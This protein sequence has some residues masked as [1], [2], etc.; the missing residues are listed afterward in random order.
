[1]DLRQ[2]TTEPPVRILLVRRHHPAAIMK[3]MILVMEVV[4]ELFAIASIAPLSIVRELRIVISSIFPIPIIARPPAELCSAV[5]PIQFGCVR[6][7]PVPR[8]HPAA[9]TILRGLFMIPMGVR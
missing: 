7:H 5:Q 8:L 2:N 1:M 6:Y 4:G 3:T 9:V